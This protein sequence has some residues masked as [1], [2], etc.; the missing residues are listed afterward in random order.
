MKFDNGGKSRSRRVVIWVVTMFGFIYFYDVRMKGG[1]FNVWDVSGCMYFV[2]VLG[3]L[4][5]SE[6][7]MG[8]N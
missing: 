5:R 6:G 1:F 3:N 8:E 4:W 7:R 2:F